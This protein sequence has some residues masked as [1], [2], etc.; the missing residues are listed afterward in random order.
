MYI[1]MCYLKQQDAIFHKATRS[2]NK[3]GN[4]EKV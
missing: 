2:A 4:M 3:A 1:N